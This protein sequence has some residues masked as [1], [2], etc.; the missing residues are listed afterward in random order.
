M[1]LDW[2]I[3]REIVMRVQE[4]ELQQERDLEAQVD[5]DQRRGFFNGLAVMA[6][7]VVALGGFMAGIFWTADTISHFVVSTMGVEQDG[8]Q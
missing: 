3:A 1:N 6:L 4:T 2:A 8:G 5:R 7:L